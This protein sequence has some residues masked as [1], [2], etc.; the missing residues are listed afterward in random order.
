MP[1]LFR[2]EN[3]SLTVRAGHVE[4]GN[5]N[6]PHQEKPEWKRKRK[7]YIRFSKIS[8]RKSNDSGKK[9]ESILVEKGLH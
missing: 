7:L 2:T 5:I 4:V 6:D 9:K 1:K 8:I 3:G